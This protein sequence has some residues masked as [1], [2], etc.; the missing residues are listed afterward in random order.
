M[1]PKTLYETLPYFY[2][3]LGLLSVIH[4][5][6]AL[7]RLCGALLVIAASTILTMRHLDPQPW[8]L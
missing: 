3:L 2:I 1:L 5:D 4:A 6:P 8:G 7:G